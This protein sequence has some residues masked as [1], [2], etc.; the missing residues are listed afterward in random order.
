MPSKTPSVKSIVNTITDSLL[1]SMVEK[2]TTSLLM[3]NANAK[4]SDNGYTDDNI[5]TYADLMA[6]TIDDINRGIN[7]HV[8]VISG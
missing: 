2:T 3:L 1:K 8:F 5:T 7:Q 4:I 6:Y